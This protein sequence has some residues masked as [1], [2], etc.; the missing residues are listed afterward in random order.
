MKLHI[1]PHAVHTTH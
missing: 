1:L